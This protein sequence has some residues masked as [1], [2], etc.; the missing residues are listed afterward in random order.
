MK[1]GTKDRKRSWRGVEQEFLMALLRLT[2]WSLRLHT[3]LPTKSLVKS[4]T[5]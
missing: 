3:P 1:K 5:L 2:L 4:V